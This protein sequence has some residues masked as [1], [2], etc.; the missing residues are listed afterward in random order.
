MGTRPPSLD[1]A[2]S[3]GSSM[4][5]PTDY[6]EAVKYA[7]QHVVPD[8]IPPT[9][10]FGAL[11]G[12]LFVTLSELISKQVTAEQA[13]TQLQQRMVQLEKQNGLLH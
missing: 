7:S 3:H 8:P 13:L 9:A 12:A 2:V 5:V 6:L 10:A 1:Y 4:G 11:Q